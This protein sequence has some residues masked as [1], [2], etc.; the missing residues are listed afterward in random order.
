MSVK[1]WVLSE[2]PKKVLTRSI[3]VDKRNLPEINVLQPMIGVK[4]ISPTDIVLS[5]KAKAGSKIDI[6]SLKF[7]YGWLGLNITDRIKENAKI[8]VSGLLA[9]NVTLL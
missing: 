3:F 6:D 5:F 7:L 2:K 8:T 1:F 4:I 9:N